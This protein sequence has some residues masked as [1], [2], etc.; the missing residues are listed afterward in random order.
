MFR[1]F[2]ICE[3]AGATIVED[4]RVLKEN[5]ERRVVT[6]YFLAT[7]QLW[8]FLE[9]S[10][11]SILTACGRGWQSL[12]GDGDVFSMVAVVYEVLISLPTMT[13]SLFSQL[14]GV[15]PLGSKLSQVGIAEGHCWAI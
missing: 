2:L 12:G 1:S 9:S 15:I 11:H 10:C 8:G 14:V 6:V 4:M 7:G 3:S 5:A 13:S